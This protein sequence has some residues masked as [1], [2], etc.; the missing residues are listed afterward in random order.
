MP[1]VPNIPVSSIRATTTPQPPPRA[2]PPHPQ[3][4]HGYSQLGGYQ[5]GHHNPLQPAKRTARPPYPNLS[6]LSGLRTVPKGPQDPVP[7][8]VVPPAHPTRLFVDSSAVTSP[9]DVGFRSPPVWEPDPRRSA[10]PLNSGQGMRA[11][12][13]GRGR[14]AGAPLGHPPG[15]LAGKGQIPPDQHVTGCRHRWTASSKAVRC[16]SSLKCKGL[17]SPPPKKKSFK[18]FCFFMRFQ[19][20]EQC[21]ELRET[22][23]KAL[24]GGSREAFKAAAKQKVLCVLRDRELQDVQS[25]G[26]QPSVRAG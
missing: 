20:E 17:C 1:G 10:A 4:G 18:G 6:D 7:S 21:W 13:A 16:L 3:L 19:E 9:G 11:A 2:P 24:Q 14:E 8:R 23:E 12:P 26:A 25:V 15:P 5:G 22:P